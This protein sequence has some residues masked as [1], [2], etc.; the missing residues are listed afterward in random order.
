[1]TVWL[2][3]RSVSARISDQPHSTVQVLVP[4]FQDRRDAGTVDLISATISRL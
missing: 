3:W 1:M 2:C 4:R